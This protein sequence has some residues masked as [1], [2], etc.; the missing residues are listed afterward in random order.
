[1]KK[2]L[3]NDLKEGMEALKEERE[4]K[5]ELKTTKP[6]VKPKGKSK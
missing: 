3:F 4:G 5:R 6:K 2:K 1:M